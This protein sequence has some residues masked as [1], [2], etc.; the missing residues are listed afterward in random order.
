MVERQLVCSLRTPLYYL[1]NC[2]AA[3]SVNFT[4]ATADRQTPDPWS[5]TYV[6]RDRSST[7]PSTSKNQPNP[8]KEAPNPVR[9]FHR[10]ATNSTPFPRSTL[11][12]K[13]SSHIQSAVTQRSTSPLKNVSKSEDEQGPPSPPAD[14]LADPN[15]S[16]LSKAYG[17]VLQPK[18]TLDTF[19]CYFCSTPFPH[20]ATIYPDPANLDTKTNF[21]CKPCF[22]TNGGTKGE[23]ASCQRPVLILASE[24]E[25]IENAG[26]VWHRRCFRCDGCFKDVGD[27][28]M[29]DLLGRPTCEDCFETCLKRPPMSSPSPRR[30]GTP[31]K[32]ERRSNPGGLKG[33]SRESSPHIDELHQRLGI[34]SRENSPMVERSKP[35]TRES[36]PAIPDLT[37]RLTDMTSA[38][39]SPGLHSRLSGDTTYS[40][41]CSDGSPRRRFEKPKTLATRSPAQHSSSLKMDNN[42][43]SDLD[44][45]FLFSS[46]S[47][48]PSRR[49]ASPSTSLS[50]ESFTPSTP[51]LTDF[52]DA[53][54]T[55]SA[56]ST[57]PS[58]S[59]GQQDLFSPSSNAS[60]ETPK[61]SSKCTPLKLAMS[62]P[63][64]P[65]A[66]CSKPLF[67]TQSGGRF[68]TVPEESAKALPP[69]SYHVDCFRCIVC[70]EPFEET[71]NGQ[72]VFVRSSSGC[73]HI[74]VGLFSSPCFNSL[75]N[76]QCSVLHLNVL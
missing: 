44:C 30:Y 4:Q 14:I 58:N 7:I 54:T 45:R 38:R 47:G 5:R 49:S 66:K 65:C 32:A 76:E 27:S 22:V 41:S 37:Q 24:G 1:S 62:T 69:K 53:N 63:S 61:Q 42:N 73:C 28:P 23:C 57:P 11:T 43:V 56:P 34:K 9:K 16:T 17:S 10:P 51:D 72:A 71:K 75:L 55:S 12:D 46:L 67:R 52:S 68:V 20:D 64:T 25:F 59:P 36:S 48:S 31:E 8:S 21:L 39:G 6:T 33:E 19:R 18:E 29:V 26:R 15:T 13:V 40:L 3:P 60:A 2:A 35:R 50:R 70:D 74:G